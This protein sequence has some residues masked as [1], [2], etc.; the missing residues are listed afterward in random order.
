M[1]AATPPRLAAW[2]LSHHI[3]GYRAESLAGD[4]TEEYGGG[5]GDGWYW[6]QVL[7]AVA[8]SYFRALRLYGLRLLL[9]LAAGWCALVLGV[10]ML[11][12]L[13]D[14]VQHG[15]GQL[16]GILPAQYPGTLRVL[17]DLAWT[18]LAGCIDVV[19][20]RLVVRIHPTHPRFVTGAFALSILA[21]REPI[22][23]GLAIGAVEDP[24]RIPALAQQLAATIFWMA[25]VGLGGLWRRTSAP[26]ATKRNRFWRIPR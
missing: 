12:R 17:R 26:G 15:L 18:L 7:R 24:N 5:R 3:R 16:P 21:Y 10:G 19:A 2:L 6:G 13:W 4:L 22:L 14:I 20:G 8:S 11:D 1:K 9:A 23:Y 25:C